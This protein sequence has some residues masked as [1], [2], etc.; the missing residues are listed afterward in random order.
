MQPPTPITRI[1]HWIETGSF[2]Q[3]YR[4][5]LLGL[6]TTLGDGSLLAES[7]RLASA[8]R[9]RGWSLGSSKATEQSEE[10]HEI[11]ALLRLVQRLNG[12][13]VYG[14]APDDAPPT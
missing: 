14:T 8:L 2:I 5:L 3:A 13:G 12:E 6:E 7:S 4:A 9:S 1:D 11:E 10:L